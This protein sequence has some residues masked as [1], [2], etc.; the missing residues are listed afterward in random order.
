LLSVKIQGTNFE[1]QF[2][3]NPNQVWYQNV[4]LGFGRDSGQGGYRNGEMTRK[5]DTGTQVYKLL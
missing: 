3:K 1:E 5:G 2:K 4:Q